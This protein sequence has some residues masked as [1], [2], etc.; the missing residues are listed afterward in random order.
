MSSPLRP[1]GHLPARVY[2]VRRLLVV[3]VAVLLFAYL[4]FTRIK[5]AA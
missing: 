4:A 3:G 2:W 5:A 1:R